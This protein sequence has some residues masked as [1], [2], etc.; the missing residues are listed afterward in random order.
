MVSKIP[1]N[2]PSRL[3]LANDLRKVGRLKVACDFRSRKNLAIF[4][5][6]P[7]PSTVQ[8]A[9][10]ASRPLVRRMGLRPASSILAAMS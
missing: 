1:R 5:K 2:Q 9:G 7:M 4:A 6:P 8:R 3:N 10:T